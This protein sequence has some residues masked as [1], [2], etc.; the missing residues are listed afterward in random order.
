VTAFC[1]AGLFVG[2]LFLGLL[3]SY[4]H[5]GKFERQADELMLHLVKVYPDR[6]LP[7]SGGD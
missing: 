1:G 3:N 7:K 2:I 6:F 5:R 4:R